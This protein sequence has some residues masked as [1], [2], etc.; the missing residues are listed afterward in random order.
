MWL[1]G[2]SG[3]FICGGAFYVRSGSAPCKPVQVHERTAHGS[4][5]QWG[6]DKVGKAK[7]KET[8][9]KRN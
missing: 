9:R 3:V 7:G 1:C 2:R 4:I 8:E 5:C 6:K